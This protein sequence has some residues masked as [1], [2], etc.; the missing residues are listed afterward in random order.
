[1]RHPYAAIPGNHTTRANQSPSRP[2]HAASA[3][4][5]TPIN[6]NRTWIIR[7]TVTVRPFVTQSFTEHF[8]EAHR[9]FSPILCKSLCLLR[10]SLCPSVGSLSSYDTP[11]ISFNSPIS[12]DAAAAAGDDCPFSRIASAAALPFPTESVGRSSWSDS[13]RY[14]APGRRFRP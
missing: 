10:G 1:M 7:Y 11:M 14:R 8:T 4:P 2:I 9:G 12:D 5:T 3:S 6:P 13:R